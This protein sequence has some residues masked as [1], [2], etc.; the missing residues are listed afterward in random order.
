MSNEVEFVDGLS[1]EAPKSGAPDFVKM[2]IGI[3]PEKLALWLKGKPEGEW[4][5]L[6]VKVSKKGTWYAS[7]DNWKPDPNR[8][9][10]PAQQPVQQPT[11]VTNN[12]DAF[13]D[14]VIPF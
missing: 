7:V 8:A 13:D 3:Q 6:Q 10:Q 2:K 4:I 1:V 14:E 5:N 12:N 9:Q 11:Q